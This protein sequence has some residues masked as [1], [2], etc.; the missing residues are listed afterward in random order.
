MAALHHVDVYSNW[1]V[2]LTKTPNFK[3]EKKQREMAQKK[4]NQ[5][6]EQ[7]KAAR[8]NTPPEPQAQ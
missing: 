7:R 6:N 5:L 8:K 4:K 2:Q 3:Q 1:R